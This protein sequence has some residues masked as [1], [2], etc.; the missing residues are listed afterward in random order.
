VEYLVFEV[1]PAHREQFIAVD[2]QIW[3]SAL[4][5][6][7]GFVAK[8]VWVDENQPGQV[9]LITYWSSYALWKAIPSDEL[10]AID[11][12]FTQAFG[13]P[14]TLIEEGHKIHRWFRV[15]QTLSSEE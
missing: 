12:R 13:H 7:R 11:E 6:Q 5:S 10:E 1:D 9:T 2:D 3:T 4:R 14:F 15:H 8:E